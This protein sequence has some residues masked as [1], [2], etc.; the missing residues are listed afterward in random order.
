VPVID[1]NERLLGAITV[2][3]VLDHLLPENWRHD[4]RDSAVATAALENIEIE[5]V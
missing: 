4:H 2:D 5:E 3:D 1:A